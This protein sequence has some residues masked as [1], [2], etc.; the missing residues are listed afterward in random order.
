MSYWLIN[1]IISETTRCVKYSDRSVYN[2]PGARHSARGG[3]DEARGVGDLRG[4][5]AR[6]LM[7][8][9]CSWEK[10]VSVGLHRQSR[11]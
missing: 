8:G 1:I 3:L 10:V 5:E 7:R 4:S 9:E 6:K 2:L 11:W